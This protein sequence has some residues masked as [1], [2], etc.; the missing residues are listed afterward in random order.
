[1]HYRLIKLKYSRYL[2]FVYCNTTNMHK[3]QA[4]VDSTPLKRRLYPPH[5]SID[6]VLLSSY[7]VSMS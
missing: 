3:R 4:I 2:A 1:M 5:S 7:L 6:A